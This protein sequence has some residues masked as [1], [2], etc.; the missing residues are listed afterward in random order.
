M[1]EKFDGKSIELI[2][3]RFELEQDLAEATEDQLLIALSDRIA[4]MIEYNMEYLLSLLYRMDVLEVNI[5]KALNPANPDPAN[6][7]LAKLIIDRQK[8]RI[9]TRKDYRSPDLEDEDEWNL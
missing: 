1:T 2:S 9:Q 4:W 7:A 6:V 8:L 3:G 5:N